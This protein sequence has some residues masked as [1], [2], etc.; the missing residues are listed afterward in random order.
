MEANPI[1]FRDLTYIFLAAIIGGLLAWRV[2]L[3][4][5]LGLLARLTCLACSINFDTVS[6]G[7]YHE[8]FADLP[9]SLSSPSSSLA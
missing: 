3:P 7:C 6:D 2:R 9:V 5:I 8:G 4:L 1:L